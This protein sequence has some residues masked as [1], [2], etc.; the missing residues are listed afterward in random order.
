M[1]VLRMAAIVPKALNACALVILPTTSKSLCVRLIHRVLSAFR[2][3]SSVRESFRQAVTSGPSS[4]TSFSFRLITTCSSSIMPPSFYGWRL[5]IVRA[6]CISHARWSTF[7]R[8]GFGLVKGEFFMAIKSTDEAVQLQAAAMHSEVFEIG[9]FA[10]NSRRQMLPRVWDRHTLLRSISWLRL[11]NGRGRNIYIRP[12]GEHRLSLIDDIGWRAVGRLKEE[13]FEPAVI[14]E[15]SPGNFQ[16]WL[17]HGVALSK[18]LSSIAARLFARRVFGD[19]ASADLRHFGGLAG[20]TNRKEKDRKEN[21]VYPFVFLHE[22][23]GR[24]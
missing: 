10:P 11:K 21:G 23:S 6:I 24:T 16:V 13:G 14:V 12:S 22:A 9:L 19:P 5:Y 4:R 7:V 2:R 3:T 1:T 20:F 17:N 15:T 18:D 8:F